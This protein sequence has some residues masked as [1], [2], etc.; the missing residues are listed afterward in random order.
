MLR[1]HI[2][3]ESKTKACAESHSFIIFFM[4]N[5]AVFERFVLN[6]HFHSLKCFPLMFFKYCQ[7]IKWP[8]IPLFLLKRESTRT[9]IHTC[10]LN[11]CANG[12]EGIQCYCF[13][14]KTKWLKEL[15][16]VRCH[17]VCHTVFQGKQQE[18]CVN[19]ESWH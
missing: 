13:I 18:S 11:M 17:I 6:V 7:A 5:P 2:H 16:S 10:I 19:E 12:A 1:C 8:K 9:H 14:S 3:T 15:L 4:K